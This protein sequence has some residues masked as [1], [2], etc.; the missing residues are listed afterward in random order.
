MGKSARMAV[1]PAPSSIIRAVPVV[2]SIL[3]GILVYPFVGFGMDY[4]SRPF[5]R[6]V[7]AT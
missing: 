4:L 3:G 2:P 1:M 6:R 5:D 7:R